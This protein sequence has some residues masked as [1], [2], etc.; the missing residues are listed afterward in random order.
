M[1]LLVWSRAAT[2]M[3]VV[4]LCSYLKPNKRWF[5]IFV[6]RILWFYIYQRIFSSLMFVC[7][8]KWGTRR[9]AKTALATIW[10]VCAYSCAEYKIWQRIRELL[11]STKSISWRTTSTRRSTQH[12]TKTQRQGNFLLLVVI[13][14]RSFLHKPTQ[15]LHRN[16]P[17]R[18]GWVSLLRLSDE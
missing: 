13:V 2:V 1:L 15:I 9:K 3:W 6:S 18:C 7:I 11:R 8:G 5:L 12:R 16:N 4:S 14:S 17:A 10:A